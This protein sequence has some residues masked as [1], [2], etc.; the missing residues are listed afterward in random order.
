MKCV[1][2][3]DEPLAIDIIESYMKQIGGLEII[4]KCTNPL[5]AISLMNKHKIDLVFLDIEMPNLTGIDLV[6]AIKNIPQFIFTTAYPEYALEGTTSDNQRV[7]IVFAQCDTK[8]KV[9]TVIDLN[10][11]WACDCP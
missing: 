2:I 7:R 3:D 8:S 4:A 11:E 10:K 9:V 6:R 1:I 5:D